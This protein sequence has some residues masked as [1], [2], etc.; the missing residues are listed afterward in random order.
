MSGAPLDELYFV[1]LYS[2]VGSVEIRDPSRTYWS[3][4]K[5][6]YTKEFVWFVPNDDNR[7]EDGKDLR[8]EFLREERPILVRQAGKNEWL[9][10]GCSVLEM[11]VGLSRRLAFEADREPRDW[12]WE[13]LDNLKLSSYRDS[14]RIPEDRVDEILDRLIFRTY[15][16]DGVGGLFPLDDPHE[17]QREVEIWYQLSAYLLERE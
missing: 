14:D 10:M 1:W 16:S 3:I 6:L 12:F 17:D 4:I 8:R 11:M 13:M 2:Q 5:R 15:R 7:S 9:R